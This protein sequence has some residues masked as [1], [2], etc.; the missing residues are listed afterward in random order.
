VPEDLRNRALRKLWASDPVY[1][2]RDGLVDYDEDFT[3][4]TLVGSAVRTLYDAVRGYDPPEE[5][6][7]APQAQGEDAVS[8][9]DGC[10]KAAEGSSDDNEPQA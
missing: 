7:A 2:V 10:A 5:E 6:G 9:G 4:T 1:A 3:A 8:Q